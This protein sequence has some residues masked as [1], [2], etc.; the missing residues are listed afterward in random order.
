MTGTEAAWVPAVLSV[1]GTGATMVAEE[2]AA[3][4]RRTILNNQLAETKKAQ[5]KT[6]D[7]VVQEAQKFAPEARTEAMDAQAEAN[8]Q[9]AQKDLGTTPTI[10]EGSGDVG[11]V[12]SDYLTAKADKAV[13]EG[14]RLTAIAKALSRTRAPGRLMEDEGIRRAGLTGDLG[15]IWSSARAQG[16]AAGL[17]AQSVETPWYGNLGQIASAAAAAYGT[18]GGGGTG[19][20]YSLG[21]ARFG[22]GG[23]GPKLGEQSGGSFWGNP[24]LGRTKSGI[25]FA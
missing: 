1:L 14:D 2:D 9:Q 6:S 23:S 24:R 13:A 3:N 17:D 20:D 4:K 25:Q 7:M 15:S 19:T 16:Q 11:N 18:G 5:D 21:N 22:E 8:Y 10:I 12:S